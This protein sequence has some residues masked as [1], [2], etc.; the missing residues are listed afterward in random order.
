METVWWTLLLLLIG[1]DVFFFDTVTV[2]REWISIC[3]KYV[4]LPTA[5]GGKDFYAWKAADFQG[6]EFPDHDDFRELDVK[7]IV[8]AEISK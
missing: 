4:A 7:F 6:Y 1:R 3:G 5:A 8:F 2:R